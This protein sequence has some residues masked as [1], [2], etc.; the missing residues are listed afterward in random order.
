MTTEERI[1]RSQMRSP[2]RIGVLLGICLG[3]IFV[4]VGARLLF[5]L[6]HQVDWGMC[7]VFCVGLLL[8]S[9][10]LLPLFLVR[11]HTRSP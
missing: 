6:F 3:T 5:S 7:V 8:A 9:A 10:I 11:K 1:D 4:L 2:A